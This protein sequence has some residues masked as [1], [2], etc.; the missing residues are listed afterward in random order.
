MPE[1]QIFQM[2]SEAYGPEAA[3]RY[4]EA[5]R[6]QAQWDLRVDTYREQRR[7]IMDSGLSAADQEAEIAR[8][9]EQHFSGPE[10]MRIE[11]I[12]RMYDQEGRP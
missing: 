12:D 1:E 9:R 11:V 6:E 8:L 2:R 5:D 4:A 10:L 7:A 3:G